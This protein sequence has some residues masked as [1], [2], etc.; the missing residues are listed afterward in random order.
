[1]EKR[2]RNNGSPDVS[3]RP[4]AAGRSGERQRELT[5]R[6]FAKINLSIDVG[7]PGNDGFHP[8]DMIMQQLFFHDDVTVT[9]RE[10]P[11]GGTGDQRIRLT[12]NRWYLPTGERNLAYKAALLMIRDYGRAVPSGLIEIRLFKR[13]PVAAGLAGGSG[14]GAAVLHGLNAV[15]DLGLSLDEIFRLGEELGSD[16]PFCAMGQANASPGLPENVRSD[17]RAASCARATG[18]GTILEPVQGIRKQIVIAKPGLSVSTAEVYRGIDRRVIPERPDNDRLIRDIEARNE[19][20]YEN[21]IN[22]LE[23]YTLSEYKEVAGLKDF[24]SG[25]GAEKVLMSG[26]GPTVFAV[27]RDVE[28]AE[29]ACARAREAGYEAYR[30]RTL[31]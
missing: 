12:S 11:G 4:G 2:K 27:Y 31:L 7:A 8:V 20:M 9:F 25:T 19:R 30:T 17:R 14:N 21:F 6:S 15:W 5:V 24:L 28:R 10:D 13:I 22:V 3:G 18:R 16:V 26:S 29:D 23:N 1:M